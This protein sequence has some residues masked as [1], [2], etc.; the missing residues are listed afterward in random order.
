MNAAGQT[1]GMLTQRRPA[2]KIVEEMVREATQILAIDL[3]VKVE[4]SL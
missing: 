2:G 1:S 3:G 4:A